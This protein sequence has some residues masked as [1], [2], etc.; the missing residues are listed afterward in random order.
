MKIVHELAICWSKVEG[1]SLYER[2]AGMRNFYRESASC[3]LGAP[4]L[5]KKHPEKDI[6]TQQYST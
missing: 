3:E 6:V 1:E 2:I 5:V 4:D